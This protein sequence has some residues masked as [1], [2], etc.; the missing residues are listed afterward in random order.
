MNSSIHENDWTT[1][2]GAA[3]GPHKPAAGNNLDSLYV[4]IEQLASVLQ[5][6]YGLSRSE[7]M[8]KVAALKRAFNEGA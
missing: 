7:A 2:R 5:E 3:E 6:K 4:R 8:R 1:R